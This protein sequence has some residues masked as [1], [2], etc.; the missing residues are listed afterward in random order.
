MTK[1]HNRFIGGATTLALAALALA[2]PAQ[3]QEYTMKFATLTI[4]DSQ[5]EFIKMYKTELERATNGRIKVEI[6]PAGQL[7]NAQRQTEG[8]RLGTIEGVN[9]P[10]E[11]F[12]G[13][14]QRFQAPAMAGLFRDADHARKVLTTPAFRQALADMAIT[15]GMIVV[16]AHLFDTQ[17]F[18]Y[19]TPVTKLADFAGKRTRVL[20]SEAEQQATASLGAAPV[21]MTLGEVLPAIQQ[22]TI[23]GANSGMPVFL[24]FKYF[25]AAPNQIDTHLWALISLG[26]VSKPWYDKLP[27]DLQK[28]VRDAGAKVEPELVK[29][30]IARAETDNK[31]WAAAGGKTF[32][33]SDAEQ[34]EAVKKADAAIQPV[35]N[36]NASMKEFYG[37]LKA[38]ADSV[39]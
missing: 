12:V 2:A 32:K 22:G 21:P 19:K 24:A 28:A 1:W 9:G 3:A 18:V 34:A 13:A 11:L 5:H 39:K 29:W 37:K 6:Y 10:S 17:S 4:N 23:D 8:L 16:S 33:L 36:K 15:R 14:D 25:D 26:L 38:A 7:G 31:A 27:P 30:S 35:L 20:A